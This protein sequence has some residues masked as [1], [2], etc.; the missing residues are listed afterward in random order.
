MRDWA[1]KPPPATRSRAML[2]YDRATIGRAAEIIDMPVAHHEES[3]KDQFKTMG[4]RM[5]L[6][7]ADWLEMKSRLEVMGDDRP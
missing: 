2:N 5:R 1:T 4:V 7:M 6:L 3:R